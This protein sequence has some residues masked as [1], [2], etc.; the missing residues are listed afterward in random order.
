MERYGVGELREL[1]RRLRDPETGCPWDLAQDF[2][3]LVRHTIEETYE[4][5][6]AIERDDPR[7]IREELGDYLFQA[8]FYAQVA[9]ERGLFDFDD[10]TH[11]IVAKLL[12]RH[13][14]VFPEGTLGS[15]RDPGTAPQTQSI[16]ETWERSKQ[17]DREARAELSALDD[18]PMALPALARA[19]KLQRRASREGFDWTAWEG[20]M[21]KLA[22]E[23]AELREAATTTAVCQRVG[24]RQGLA[25]GDAAPTGSG[26]HRRSRRSHRLECMGSP[27]VLAA[28]GRLAGAAG[29]G[30]RPDLDRVGERAFRKHGPRASARLPAARENP[31]RLRLQRGHLRNPRRGEPNR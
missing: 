10:V 26:R 28:H 2:R 21:E 31:G 25:R 3:S 5:V 23:S 19:E 18:V 11:A 6:D 9:S 1:M 22:E 12:R 4:L 27:A 13:P 14:H 24:D 15:R 17:T 20:V 7:A 8:V 16:R 30:G 29:R